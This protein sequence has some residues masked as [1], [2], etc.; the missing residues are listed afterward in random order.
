MFAVILSF[1]VLVSALCFFLIYDD[2][3]DQLFLNKDAQFPQFAP[4]IQKVMPKHRKAHRS[5]PTTP[6]DKRA[7]PSL[8]QTAVTPPPKPPK[9]V[10][11]PPAYPPPPSYP[12]PPATPPPSHFTTDSADFTPPSSTSSTGPIAPPPVP[13]RPDFSPKKQNRDDSPP[14]S[15]RRVTLTDSHDESPR[16]SK[17]PS[18]LS[19]GDSPRSPLHVD[20]R[21]PSPSKTGSPSFSPGTPMSV[22]SDELSPRGYACLCLTRSYCFDP[23]AAL[24]VPCWCDGIAFCDLLACLVCCGIS[25]G[26]SSSM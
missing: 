16:P 23:N 14:P 7:T 15:P 26:T 4:F 3:V 17:K 9:T 1:L 22:S 2:G 11:P 6:R 18:P 10:P 12:P 5:P 13:P 21:S 20:T 19:G 24:E 25:F 8:P